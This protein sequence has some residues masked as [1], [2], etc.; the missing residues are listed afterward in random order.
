MQKIKTKIIP[1]TNTKPTRI[2]A[3]SDS[4]LSVTI[5]RSC[6]SLIS[7]DHKKAANKLKIKLGWTDKMIGGH[8]KDGMI[9]VFHN[10]DFI[11]RNVNLFDTSRPWITT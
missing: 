11:L 5:S 10:D 1:S 9:F 7:N 8:T 3:I 6:D 4:G 2:K